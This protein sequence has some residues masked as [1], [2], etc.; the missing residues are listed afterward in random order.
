MTKLAE[1]V[2]DFI[3]N[4]EVKKSEVISKFSGRGTKMSEVT[5]VNYLLF[6]IRDGLLT[7]KIYYKDNGDFDR[8]KGKTLIVV[9]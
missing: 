7:E 5:F 9:K 2:I 8:N 3:G 6:M 1:Q 4:R